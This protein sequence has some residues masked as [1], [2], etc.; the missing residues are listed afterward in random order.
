MKKVWGAQGVFLRVESIELQWLEKTSKIIKSNHHPTPTMLTNHVPQCHNHRL[1]SHWECC[2]S[3]CPWPLHV[4]KER[5]NQE[6]IAPTSMR[7]RM[8][9][10]AEKSCCKKLYSEISFSSVNILMFLSKLR[11]LKG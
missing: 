2:V 1:L 6:E 5:A 4:S 8:Q 10:L 9:L 11:T 7:R 3:W